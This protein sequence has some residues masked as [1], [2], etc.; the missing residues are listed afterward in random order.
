MPISTPFHPRTSAL[1]SSY[2][3][4]EWAGYRAVCS[5]DVHHEREYTAFRH[6]A[7]LLDATPLFKYEI[8]GPDAGR[9]LAHVTVKDARRMRVGRVSYLCWTDA[10]GQVLDDGTLTRW[11]DNHYRLT[12]ADPSY[13]WLAR[14]AGGFEVELRD[15]SD[16]IGV[17]ALQGPRSR[18]ILETCCDAG[19][20]ETPVQAL[21]FFG[22]TRAR[23]AGRSI[24]LTR[25]GYTGDLGFELWVQPEDALVVWD[26]LVEAGA[27]HGLVP[28]GLDALD[29][30]R[31]EAGFL[32]GGID[33]TSAR[34]ALI[35]EQTSSPSEIGL[36]WAVELEREPFIGQAALLEEQRAGARWSSV[37]LDID[38]QELEALYD[39]HGLPPDLPMHAW[40]SSIPLYVGA[41]QVGYATSGAWSPTLKKNLAIATL[42]RAHAADGS[43]LDIEWTVEHRR[44]R[45]SARVTPRPFFDP[46]RK[47]STPAAL[48]A[49]SPA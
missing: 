34:R 22:A 13:A 27:P 42:Q 31:I 14:H 33:Y 19:P 36:G 17:L 37:G 9:F 30:T 43:K 49:A 10:R 12:S 4:K 11:D 6:S 16:Q 18:A 48:A 38:W 40:R 8:Q 45:V 41:Q 23:V 47:R 29:V 5:F 15:A 35:P 3:W 7:G 26:T 1:C 46:E 21:R 28:A 25:T 44:E 20:G 32:L 2:K 24:E 39:S